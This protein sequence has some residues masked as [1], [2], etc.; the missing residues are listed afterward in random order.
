[1]AELD[2]RPED[3]PSSYLWFVGGSFFVLATFVTIALMPPLAL[4]TAVAAWFCY[5]VGIQ[6]NR[7]LKAARERV[8]PVS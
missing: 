8:S 4:L 7:R 6:R 2:E 3:I 1:M 5:Y